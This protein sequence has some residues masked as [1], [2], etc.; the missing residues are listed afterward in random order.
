MKF[1]KPVSSKTGAIFQKLIIFIV[2]TNLKKK[3]L[4]SSCGDI[5]SQENV[6]KQKKFSM[7]IQKNDD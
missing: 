3:K 5:I 6:V 4:N 1:S 2:K 7:L